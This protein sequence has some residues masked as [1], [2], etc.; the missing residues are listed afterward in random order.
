[1]D[2]IKI[3]ELTSLVDDFIEVTEALAESGDVVWDRLF[4]DIKIFNPSAKDLFWKIS[5]PHYTNDLDP[6]WL[7]R[8]NLTNFQ[9]NL[10]CTLLYQ[11][12]VYSGEEMGKLRFFRP[13]DYFSHV[14]D[15]MTTTSKMMNACRGDKYK[16]AVIFIYA[17]LETLNSDYGSRFT[18]LEFVNIAW[19]R[20]SF[21]EK[22]NDFDRL[23]HDFLKGRVCDWELDWYVQTHTRLLPEPDHIHLMRRTK[24]EDEVDLIEY[25]ASSFVLM[26]NNFCILNIKQVA[27][28]DDFLMARIAKIEITRKTEYEERNNAYESRI[29]K[30]RED[31]ETEDKHF[32]DDYPEHCNNILRYTDEIPLIFKTYQSLHQEW[33]KLNR[34]TLEQLVWSAPMVTLALMFGK[35]DVAIAKLC[36]RLDVT[37]PHGT[38]WRKIET[39]LVEYPAGVPNAAHLRS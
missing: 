38:I 13:H 1:M 17:Y 35:S 3:E 20:N 32:I 18:R 34:E 14:L 12:G 24:F 16:I 6:N 26:S 21:R 5:K 33:T 19:Q 22:K 11:G 37:R 7:E 27:K 36:K 15:G 9:L 39:G 8:E 25:L 31:K 28:Q 2:D 4:Q 10:Q 30:Q 29:R 23:F